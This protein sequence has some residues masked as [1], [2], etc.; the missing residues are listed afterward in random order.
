MDE[1]G[2]SIVREALEAQLRSEDIDR[3]IGRTVRRRKLDFKKY[4]EVIG[5]LRDLAKADST[6]VEVAARKI[7]SKE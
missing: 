1:E 2:L 3:A 5:E 4:I 7:I 6:T